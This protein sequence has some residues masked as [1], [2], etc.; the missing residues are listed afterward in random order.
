MASRRRRGD[1][2]TRGARGRANHMHA[3]PTMPPSHATCY[4]LHTTYYIVPATST[5]GH[6]VTTSV[7][8]P[9]SWPSYTPDWTSDVP[10]PHS[11]PCTYTY[12][13]ALIPHYTTLHY[14]TRLQCLS[15]SQS[16]TLQAPRP[17]PTLPLPRESTSSCARP[18]SAPAR[19]N[20]STSVHA[21]QS[22]MPTSCSMSSSQPATRTACR[23]TTCSE[24]V[25]H[26]PSPRIEGV[27][28]ITPSLTRVSVLGIRS[29][30]VSVSTD[31]RGWLNDGLI[32]WLIV[33]GF[34]PS[35][36]IVDSGSPGLE[37][38]ARR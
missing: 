10:S 14:P 32:G 7:D 16:K 31:A 26:L 18:P 5:L 36:L 24:C 21:T 28:S 37:S 34:T 2:T 11:R 15:P 19:V 20:P 33:V 4:M 1:V 8:E 29:M 6:G 17:Q 30:Y 38:R 35:F 13:H 9:R 27:S 12:S 23:L 22:P 25:F 3:H